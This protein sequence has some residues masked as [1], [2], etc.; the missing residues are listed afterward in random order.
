MDPPFLASHQPTLPLQIEPLDIKLQGEREREGSFFSALSKEQYNRFPLADNDP[1][2]SVE[3]Q[4]M[5]MSMD[6]KLSEGDAMAD[7]DGIF[8]SFAWLVSR[9]PR[10]DVS[11]DGNRLRDSLGFSKGWSYQE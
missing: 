9:A 7:A 10:N 11:K 1:G 3:M 2:C 5:Q 4:G 8:L 6:P